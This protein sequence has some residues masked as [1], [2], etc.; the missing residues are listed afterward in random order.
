MA[1]AKPNKQFQPFRKVSKEILSSILQ[2]IREGAPH[3]FAAESNGISGRHFSNIVAQGIVDLEFNQP[4]TLQAWVVLSLRKIQN[5]EIKSCKRDIR[6][7]KKGHKGAEWTLER[8]YWKLFGAHAETKELAEEIEQ[9]R[10][11]KL[12]GEKGN[13]QVDNKGKEEDTEI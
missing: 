5:D 2:E 12:H 11:E 1:E 7:Q 10:T 6:K 9:L 4:D 13:E 3:K 8:V